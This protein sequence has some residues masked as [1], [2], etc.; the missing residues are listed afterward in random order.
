MDR[1]V[2]VGQVIRAI[3]I[4]NH[5]IANTNDVNSCQIIIP[6]NQVNR[7]HGKLTQELSSWLKNQIHWMHWVLSF[8][9]SFQCVQFANISR[10]ETYTCSVCSNSS[11]AH[12]KSKVA[13]FVKF[14]W[15]YIQVFNIIQVFSITESC[16]E[17]PEEL[18]PAF[19]FTPS[20]FHSQNSFWWSYK[21]I[22]CY[23]KPVFSA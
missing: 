7:K 8:F 4:L 11:E 1:T 10:V 22:T 5:P 16:T 12:F 18:G 3:C 19:K 17:G 13:Y 9:F 23:S 20:L 21:A 2:K 15:N 14:G 6:Q